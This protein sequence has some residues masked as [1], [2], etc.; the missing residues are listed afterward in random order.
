MKTL[1]IDFIR[2]KIAD[3][4]VVY[5]R[6]ESIFHTGNYSHESSDPDS[7][8]FVYSVDGNYGDYTVTV[9][10]GEEVRTECTC[11][12]PAAGCK[13]V[14]AV[15]LDLAN[16]FAESARRDDP[17]A[18]ETASDCLSY[19]EIRNEVFESREKAAK[20]GQFEVRWG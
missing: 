1:S 11:P 2:D 15:C 6:C 18:A 14:V 3:S 10:L 5:K 9:K 13:H 8:S 17:D 4:K 12:Y 19:E 20:I 16:K 7:G